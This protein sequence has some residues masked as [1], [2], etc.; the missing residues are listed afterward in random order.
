MRTGCGTPVDVVVCRTVKRC[1]DGPGCHP[2]GPHETKCACA[3]DEEP[4]LAKAS[5]KAWV[6]KG[7][8]DCVECAT[9]AHPNADGTRSETQTARPGGRREKQWLKS[10]VG[11]IRECEEGVRSQGRSQAWRHDVADCQ[12]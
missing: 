7:L 8:Y 2:D 6:E 4:F 3:D 12:R 11:D 10:E 1:C 9:A 5:V